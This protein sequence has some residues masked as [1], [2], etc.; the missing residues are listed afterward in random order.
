M[1]TQFNH[2]LASLWRLKY[3]Y[4]QSLLFSKQWNQRHEW[5]SLNLSV[6]EINDACRS[7][8]LRLFGVFSPL[9]LNRIV[10][11]TQY[12]KWVSQFSPD[13]NRSVKK[14][15]VDS[16][17][18]L[19]KNDCDYCSSAQFYPRWYGDLKD[20]DVDDLAND[21]HTANVS[22]N[23]LLSS[24]NKCSIPIVKWVDLFG[25]FRNLLK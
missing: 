12:N 11:F 5:W 10:A 14:K 2:G 19:F 18:Y 9:R 3:C 7:K 21:Q 8:P 25:T 22:S 15:S 24:S 20:N 16:L 23:P 17:Y 4:K 1:R 13:D 6:Y